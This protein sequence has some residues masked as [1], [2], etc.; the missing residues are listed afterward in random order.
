VVNFPVPT[1]TTLHM[2]PG[3]WI[4]RTVPVRITRSGPHSLWGEA[5]LT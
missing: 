1:D 2:P 4:G 3:E 5:S